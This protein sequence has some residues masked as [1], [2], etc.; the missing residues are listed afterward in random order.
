VPDRDPLRIAMWSGPRNISTA[1]MRSWGNRPDTHVC[2]E[3][4][5]AHY[6][7]QTDKDHPGAEEVMAAQERD[8]RVVVR[9]LTGPIPRGKSIYY[10]KHMAHHL[11]SCIERGWL[12]EVVN[13]FL[14]RDPREMLTSLARKLEEPLL[15]DTG[16]PQQVE[17]FEQ[18][19]ERTGRVPPVIDAKDV[20]MDPERVLGLLCEA[21]G[22]PFT[23]DMLSWPPGRR[24]TDGVW[25]KYWYENVEASTGFDP[26]R[27]KTD[28]VPESMTE[29][30][31]SCLEYYGVLSAQRLGGA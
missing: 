1:L 25:A 30:Y 7:W 14:I 5:Y 11:L 19:R 26:Y 28:A 22:V 23:R 2:D 13:C 4:L 16:L 31:D 10:Q 18:V 17:I 21:L 9:G 3:P 15:E 29:L 24:E 8:W 12:N 27:P 20:L 6:L